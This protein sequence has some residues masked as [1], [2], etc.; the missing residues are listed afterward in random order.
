MQ[1]ELSPLVAENNATM[2]EVC[3]EQYEGHVI[4][5]ELRTYQQ[6]RNYCRS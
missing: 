1:W 2:E 4:F 5:P 6:V 3:G